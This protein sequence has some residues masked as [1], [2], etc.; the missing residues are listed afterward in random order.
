M[1]VDG[2]REGGGQKARERWVRVG[3]AAVRER[4]A[5]QV[6]VEGWGRERERWVSVGVVKDGD[7]GRAMV[8]VGLEGVSS[9]SQDSGIEAVV[10]DLGVRVVVRNVFSSFR[11]ME[12]PMEPER[13]RC[14]KPSAPVAESRR[15]SSRK[16]VCRPC[17]SMP[18]G[19][20]FAM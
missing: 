11:E 3:V 7:G 5:R 16:R 15:E 8:G 2:W 1:G 20:Y 17:R 4:R 14:D 10:G 18:L 6:V 19:L 12:R 9:V 13:S